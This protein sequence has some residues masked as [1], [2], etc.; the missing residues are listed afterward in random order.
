[1]VL[2]RDQ[3]E[4]LEPCS[5]G[6]STGPIAGKSLDWKAAYK[7]GAQCTRPGEEGNEVGEAMPCRALQARGSSRVSS[8]VT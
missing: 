5:T 7:P 1:M 2:I 3:N 8:H 4:R 6:K